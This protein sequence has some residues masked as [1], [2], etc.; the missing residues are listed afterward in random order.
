MRSRFSIVRELWR[1][2]DGRRP[3]RRSSAAPPMPS[4]SWKAISAS[5]EARMSAASPDSRALVAASVDASADRIVLT[6]A[7]RLRSGVRLWPYG[8]GCD[9]QPR[10]VDGLDLA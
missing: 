9:W 7:E 1:D 5:K 3:V 4:R 2:P 8:A 10:T 6:T